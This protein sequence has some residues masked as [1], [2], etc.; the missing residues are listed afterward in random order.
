MIIHTYGNPKDP[1]ILMLH[2][3]LLPG[4]Q[5]AEHMGRKIPGDYFLI[6][7]D[8]AGHGDDPDMCFSPEED[9]KELSSF[10][11]ET[12]IKEI[13]LL[14]AAS[15]G[16]I[17]AME[18][19]KLNQFQIKHIHLDGTPLAKLTGIQTVLSPLLYKMA[20]KKT[21]KDPSYLTKTLEPIYGNELGNTMSR[22]MSILSKKCLSQIM[23]KCNAGCAVDLE[24]E[25]CHNLV[26]EWG[27]KEFDIAKGKP[28]AEKMY[29]WAKIIV[30]EGLDHCE[31]LGKQPEAYAQE[32][33]KELAD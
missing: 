15:M 31:F 27:E 20:L 10:L 24:E 19:L 17:T 13:E 7:P 1:V 29:P 3:M 12:G 9:A 4:K 33:A 22:Q 30:R 6:A 32:I 28:L 11:N 23:E 18:F 21:K 25:N 26:F 14:Y 8:Q 16:S 2:P 5:L